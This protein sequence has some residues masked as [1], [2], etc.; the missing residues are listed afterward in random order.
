MVKCKKT[1][2]FILALSVLFCGCCSYEEKVV[3]CKVVDKKV[4]RVVEDYPITFG[5]TTIAVPMEATYYKVKIAINGTEK[6]IDVPEHIWNSVK[7]G[8]E[9]Y[10]RLIKNTVIDIRVDKK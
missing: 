8:D 2:A 4:D 1:L 10:V 6:W 5:I 3:R 7:I 9:I